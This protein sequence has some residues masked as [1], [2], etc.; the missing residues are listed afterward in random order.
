MITGAAIN[1]EGSNQECTQS[2]DSGALV[3]CSYLTTVDTTPADFAVSATSWASI[4]DGEISAYAQFST[5][6]YYGTSPSI[7]ASA[8]GTLTDQLTVTGG[9][10]A[11]F[12]TINSEFTGDFTAETRSAF[13]DGSFAVASASGSYELSLQNL[14]TPSQS[15]VIEGPSTCSVTFWVEYGW[16]FS[17][18]QRLGVSAGG[19]Y[20]TFESSPVTISGISAQADASHTAT[21][22]SIFIRDAGGNLLQGAQVN[23]SSGINY[24]VNPTTS[25]PE[26]GSLLLMLVAAVVGVSRMVRA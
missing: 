18:F 1:F 4:S 19:V 15:C 3:G 26:P 20:R 7:V 14:R 13:P 25:V 23:S 6:G 10:G 8:G 16:V 17:V 9:T 22:T 5:T 2:S 11:I 12:V 21:I 24:S